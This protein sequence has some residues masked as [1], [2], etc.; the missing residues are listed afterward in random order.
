MHFLNRND[1]LTPSQTEFN[2][3]SDS[4]EYVLSLLW[5]VVYISRKKLISV[6]QGQHS[7]PSL[8][9]GPQNETRQFLNNLLY[10]VYTFFLTDTQN[11]LGA[12]FLVV[13]R[14]PFDAGK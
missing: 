11:T 1:K 8:H 6:E 9:P 5:H 3:A 10:N 7:Q 4:S 2:T 12:T 14:V 13:W